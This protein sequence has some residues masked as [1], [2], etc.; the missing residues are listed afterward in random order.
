MLQQIMTRTMQ[1]WSLNNLLTTKFSQGKY[2]ML[3]LPVFKIHHLKHLKFLLL[4]VKLSLSDSFILY[5]QIFFVLPTRKLLWMQRGRFMQLTSHIILSLEH[6]S[7][8]SWLPLVIFLFILVWL[9][10]QPQPP[11]LLW[12]C[13]FHKPPMH[14]SH[15]DF[16]T[17]YW[18]GYLYYLFFCV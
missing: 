2:L 18:I 15:V 10:L 16:H 4:V 13:F 3:L 8:Q 12:K 9:H 1:F 5:Q 17:I 14:A 11:Y 6:E 7:E